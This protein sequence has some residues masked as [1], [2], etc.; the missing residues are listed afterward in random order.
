MKKVLQKAEDFPVGKLKIALVCGGNNEESDVSRTSGLGI[1]SVI[2]TIARESIMIDVKE[3]NWL[4]KLKKFNPDITF[5]ALHGRFGEDGRFQAIMDEIGLKYTHSGYEASFI[6][7]Q[8][9]LSK[10]IFAEHNI[11]LA[12]G[13]CVVTKNIDEQCIIRLFDELSSDKIVLKPNNSGSSCGVAIFS[14]N[15][16]IDLGKIDKRFDKYIA[17]EFIDGIEISVPV[18]CGIAL[19][20]LELHPISGWYDYQNKYTEG[21]TEHFYPARMPKDE[22]QEAMKYAEIAHE[23]IGCKTLSRADFRFNPKNN[24][25]C[26]LEINTHPGF[27]PLSIAPDVAQKEGI[28]W[29]NLIKIILQDANS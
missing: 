4:E 19:G 14:K 23:V 28:S 25:L 13:N 20:V 2:Q 6:G 22:Y 17:E 12:K 11:P 21:K 9:N 7:M 15:E 24:Q 1:F 10:T 26:L 8:K 16:S 29:E 18:L 3:K 5:N 27:T